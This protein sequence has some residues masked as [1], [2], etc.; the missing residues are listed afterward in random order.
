MLIRKRKKFLKSKE[1]SE[2]RL[3]VNKNKKINIQWKFFENVRR[4]TDKITFTQRKT[5]ERLQKC[6]QNMLHKNKIGYSN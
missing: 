6:K 1:T 3:N 2:C 5:K 4:N